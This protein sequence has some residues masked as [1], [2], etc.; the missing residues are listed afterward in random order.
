[1]FAHYRLPTSLCSRTKTT[2]VGCSREVTQVKA[3]LRQRKQK[4]RGS[5]FLSAFLS[6]GTKEIHTL[7]GSHPKRYF[8]V[9]NIVFQFS[10]LSWYNAFNKE[11]EN[12]TPLDAG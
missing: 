4:L 8:V 9:L 6:A 12:E 5:S 3:G 7:P 10:N 2:V 1:V 11:R